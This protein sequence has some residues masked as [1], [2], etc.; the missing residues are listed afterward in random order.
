M[1]IWIAARDENIAREM[2]IGGDPVPIILV[3]IV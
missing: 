1:I 3:L 2:W